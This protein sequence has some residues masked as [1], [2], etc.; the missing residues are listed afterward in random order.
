MR[1]ETRKN[2]AARHTRAQHTHQ[3]DGRVTKRGTGGGGGVRAAGTPCGWV[4]WVCG[5]QAPVCVRMRVCVAREKKM[6]VQTQIYGG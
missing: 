4:R 6:S 1:S 2:I 5:K 3:K